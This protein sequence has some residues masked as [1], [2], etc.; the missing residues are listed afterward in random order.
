MNTPDNPAEAAFYRGWL[1]L[2]SEIYQTGK[3]AGFYETP[4][5]DPKFNHAEKMML[6]VSEISEG[7]EGLRGAPFP[8]IMDDKLPDRPMIEAE[9]ADA[10]IRIMNYGSHCGL[11]IAAAII[12]KN[13]FNKTRPHKHGGKRF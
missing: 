3:N 7:V 5:T 2:A 11:D 12:A 4:A 13:A 9:L 8:G 1:A 6:V 10:V